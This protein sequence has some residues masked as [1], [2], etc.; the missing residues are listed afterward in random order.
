MQPS[1][2]P[3][4]AEW[5]KPSLIIL[6]RGNPEEMVLEQCKSVKSAGSGGPQCG[7]NKCDTTKEGSCQSC[8]AEAGGAS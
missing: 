7:Q 2:V 4:K 5:K 1:E 6:S 8:Q 3:M